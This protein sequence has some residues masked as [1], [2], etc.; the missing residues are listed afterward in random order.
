MKTNQFGESFTI[1]TMVIHVDK[2]DLLNFVHVKSLFRHISK[3]IL[4]TNYIAEAYG[5]I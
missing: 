5:D 2:F 1:Q 4:I 3:T